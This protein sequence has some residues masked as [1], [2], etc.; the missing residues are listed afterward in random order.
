M[1]NTSR[2]MHLRQLGDSKSARINKMRRVLQHK[3][4]K[5]KFISSR[6]TSVPKMR[7]SVGIFGDIRKFLNSVTLQDSDSLWHKDINLE[8]GSIN[9]YEKSWHLWM[10]MS[11][12]P[13][14][15]NKEYGLDRPDND[16][17]ISQRSRKAFK[18]LDPNYIPMCFD[19]KSI[20][21]W[22]KEAEIE[23]RMYREGKGKLPRFF[24]DLLSRKVS[25]MAS[26]EM[27]NN[28]DA[29]SLQELAAYFCGINKAS[30]H[31]IDRKFIY[32]PIP[33]GVPITI[34]YEKGMLK[35]AYTMAFGEK[36]ELMDI[37]TSMKISRSISL[38]DPIKIEGYLYLDSYAMEFINA[39][40]RSKGTRDW[41][42]SYSA[43]AD[44]ILRSNEPNRELE[45]KLKSVFDSFEYINN[46]NKLTKKEQLSLLMRE[47][48]PTINDKLITIANDKLGPVIVHSMKSSSFELLGCRVALDN[49]DEKD[50]T[51]TSEI[52]VKFAP[53]FKMTKIEIIKFE[54]LDNGCIL[55]IVHV[56]P[57]T[58]GGSVY[59]I[60]TISNETQ[61]IDLGIH[62]GD[63]IEVMQTVGAAPRI[64]RSFANGG[65]SISKYPK[66]CP[67]C[68][69]VLTR[70]IKNSE[71]IAY[72]AAHLKCKDETVEE[73]MR[74]SS[75]HGLHIPSLTE[76][77]IKKL[78]YKSKAFNYIDLI[79]LSS[80]N[81]L[82]DVIAHTDYIRLL[83]EIQSAKYTTLPRFLYALNI[84]GVDYVIAEK[85][86]NKYGSLK[87]VTTSK[88]SELA[89]YV[90]HDIAKEI[91]EW[92]MD[93][94]SQR[95]IRTL[96][97]KGI[98]ISEPDE[99][100]LKLCY[101]HTYTY[102]DYE[103]I[104]S[105]INEHT[106]SHSISDLD[107]DKLCEVA[108]KLESEHKWSLDRHDKFKDTS[109][110]IL[111][112]ESI[113]YIGKTY[114][115]DEITQLCE[116]LDCEVY[117]AEPKVD[118]VACFLQYEDGNL[119]SAYTKKANMGNNITELIRRVASIPKK[120]KSKYTGIVRGELFI[121]KENFSIINEEIGY[122]DS[123]SLLVGTINNKKE[124]RFSI[125]SSLEIF[126]FWMDTSI[127]SNDIHHALNKLGFSCSIKIPYV[128]FDNINDIKRYISN[129]AE[130]RLEQPVNIDGIVI[131]PASN[132]GICC[133][134]KF[135]REIRSSVIVSIEFF[136]TKRRYLQAIAN[137]APIQFGNRRI[138]RVYI[139]NPNILED[140]RLGSIV[141]IY[142]AIGASPVFNTIKT[143]ASSGEFIDIPK[144]CPSC[145]CKLTTIE[146]K[147]CCKNPRCSGELKKQEELFRFAKRMKF[148]ST[149]VPPGWIKQLIEQNIITTFSD[150][151][152]V[153]HEDVE[154]V[155]DYEKAKLFISQV[156]RASHISKSS[157]IM[158][159][160]STQRIKLSAIDAM[161]D[162]D[163]SIL[164]ERSVAELISYGM[165]KTQA[166]ALHEF[167][168]NNRDEIIYCL[169]YLRSIASDV[170]NV[171]ENPDRVLNAFKIR[172]ENLSIML[173]DLSVKVRVIMEEKDKELPLL[174]ASSASYDKRLFNK[175]LQIIKKSIEEDQK[176]L[177]RIEKCD[178]NIGR[179]L[180]TAYNM[181]HN[182]DPNDDHESTKEDDPLEDDTDVDL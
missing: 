58:L 149:Y 63:D 78:K 68:L 160:I 125:L 115:I 176:L 7:P 73:I 91:K 153:N 130:R 102:K 99:A 16:E 105:K 31:S 37:I 136:V 138:S 66:E 143:S 14:A 101:K 96:I 41:N 42:D 141:S 157:L 172:E 90:T 17:F 84:P 144:N 139:H 3:N 35:E 1:I 146:D 124:T 168:N 140:V 127:D 8:N 53:E 65:T 151:F 164:P 121:S 18:Y 182:L 92:L 82:E 152:R 179:M 98:V 108:D 107:Y 145:S 148:Y 165:S 103:E 51:A 117:I 97:D 163:S 133:A 15:L 19:S 80:Y 86:A 79:S 142:C 175:C 56:K 85:L 113:R 135:N 147:L 178:R 77:L 4:G 104:I 132:G 21:T 122:V 114:N 72:C 171:K 83:D 137:L 110:L 162:S 81:S 87:H 88:I 5:Y 126:P 49:N 40:C 106:K 112:K 33:N 13:E 12:K 23:M 111:A 158:C 74:F 71:I 134:Y 55:A 38:S 48:I 36:K 29:Y 27:I 95:K 43:V 118:G 169:K 28:K 94:V 50:L 155:L 93:P 59:N 26:T 150:F 161:F 173:K 57:V 70:R 131:K 25:Y 166:N 156:E 69:N 177:Y 154:S 76:N 75:I 174:L 34:V 100:V 39:E 64:Y 10:F 6:F 54:V 60:F 44:T 47:R 67:Q 61:L 32:Y 89:T 159:L 128:K 167:I 109:E 2:L 123:L 22:T 46:T 181:K 119:I 30:G 11:C 180:E 24:Y 9:D 62:D 170:A 116:R 52:S 129:V 20:E 45:L 120:L